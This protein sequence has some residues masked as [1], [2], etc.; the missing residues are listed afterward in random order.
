M[1][2]LNHLA[3][4]LLLHF[5]R[6]LPAVAGISAGA[7]WAAPTGEKPEV[8]SIRQY[9][10]LPVERKAQ[11]VDFELA[12]TVTYIDAD[13][14][15][16]MLFVQDDEG[17]AAYVPY[18]NNA[19]PFRAG[20]AILVRGQ[21]LPPSLDVSF[22]HA[23]VTRRDA[24]P[25]QP[26]DCTKEIRNHAK[27]IRKYVALE[28]YVDWVRRVDETHM[29]MSLSVD[30]LSVGCWV[31]M[32]PTTSTPDLIDR[33]IRVVGVYNAKI[34][35]DGHLDGL[36]IMVA[37]FSRIETVGHLDE[38]PAFQLPAVPIGSLRGRPTDQLMR[39]TGSVIAREVG[40]YVR[41]RDGSGQVD[42]M[43]G[44]IRPLAVGDVI[45]A[46]GYPSTD[47]PNW[48]LE[49]GFFRLSARS[50]N[51][52]APASDRPLGLAAEVHGLP[53]EEAAAGRP[54]RLTGVV[55]WS[56][57][58]SPFFFI[59]DS[60]GG[61]Q[62]MRG[63][64]D[65][66][67]RSPGRNVEIE[68]VTA[69]GEFAPVVVASRFQRVSDAVLPLAR[70]VS[71]EHA[72]SG[73]EEAQWVEMRGYLRRV[74]Q[75][76]GWKRLELAT[77]TSDFIA[78]LPATEDVSSMI[79]SV[80]RV[81]GVCTAKADERRRLTGIS[82]W[83]PGIAYVHVEEPAPAD[84]FTVPQRPLAS[85]GQ[86]ETV[87]SFNRRVRVGGVVLHHDAG[88]SVW[89]EDAGQ[90]LLVWSGTGDTLRAGDRAEAV[91]FLGR[92]S[93]RIVLRDAVIRRTGESGAPVPAKVAH[94]ATGMQAR[95]GQL[96]VIEGQLLDDVRIAGTT[97]LV[98]QAGEL[99][100]VA[101]LEEH[102]AAGAPLEILSVGSRLRLTGVHER[103][104]DQAGRPTGFR[105]HL[106]QTADVQLLAAP[107]WWTR[108]RILT[109]TGLIALGAVLF[110][111]WNTVLRRQVRDQTGQIR[112]QL[113]RE[114]RL[115]GELARAGKLEALGLLAGG[116]AHDFNNLLTVLMGNISLVR[117]EAGLTGEPAQSM[118]QAAKA[119]ARARD[120]TQ[121]LLTFAKGGAP[122]RSA[123][124][125][126][127]VVREVTEFALRGSKVSP[128]FDLPADL[129]AA[130]ADKGQ[131]GQV[132]QNIVIN[133]MQA[134]PG[135]GTVE[136]SLSNREVST[137][138]AGVLAPGRYV[139]LDIADH[140]PGI[141]TG[142]LARIFDPYFTTKKQGSGLGLATVH[143][144]VKKHAGHVTA[145]STLGRGTT[146]HI[147]LPAAA[148]GAVV[149]SVP[150]L[151][152]E[153]GKA[154]GR[155]RVLVM[156]DEAFIRDLAVSV[157]RR[158]GCQVTAVADGAAALR[159]YTAAREAGQPF[160][161]VI[162]DLTI[163]GGMGGRETMEQ[164][165]RLDPNVK[166]IVSSGYSNDLVLAN[167][168][169]HGFR[170]MIS[171]PYDVSDFTDTVD[172]VLR[173]ERA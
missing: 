143:S 123:V 112:A 166:A 33:R 32:S 95:D 152:A 119:A 68:G 111:G 107:S 39:V 20:E 61:I 140:G 30:G 60:S 141:P 14:S 124:S 78:V 44:Q 99:I 25:L 28:G 118:E 171:K 72:L 76:E 159:D 83:V 73:V 67:V 137:E 100:F 153:A 150:V 85:L 98:M 77:A 164:L 167:Y 157:L 47:G 59:A 52:T 9:W 128:R 8:T 57:P 103:E 27:F 21:F 139:R 96:V 6:L 91:G 71:V 145:E 160:D 92:Q 136:I 120:L 102:D 129:W 89:L 126:P 113:E 127:E 122:L 45:E 158:H 43:T 26:L 172:R 63:A 163:P 53:A 19:Y 82:L 161:L 69:M 132:V 133:A 121:Q 101:V 37:D 54:V 70:S 41:I 131:I 169:A 156:D 38:N 115:Q 142:D 147:W 48:R 66:M 170:G 108:G 11:P 162:L 114:A 81:H 58:N 65:S 155:V 87:Q 151:S 149:P 23:E 135:G 104:F 93:G 42:I 17:E 109:F 110:L 79:G 165:L 144:I 125:L 97:R 29:Q 2:R 7:L 5:L 138:F 50:P 49:A 4:V 105:L 51:V 148:A 94:D 117:M 74:H 64:S 15:W 130:D 31:Q 62:I 168:Q 134:M 146:F 86:F 16:R 75:T 36:E 106:R 40:R 173:G 46:V 13:P 12:C 56:H 90:S 10:L 22:E 3:G 1:F 80:I 24:P 84:P 55:T 35:T 116:I 88:K 154:N 18:G 34:G